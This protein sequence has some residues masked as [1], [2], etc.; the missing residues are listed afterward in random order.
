MESEARRRVWRCKVCEKRIQ[1]EEEEEAMRMSDEE[2]EERTGA[3]NKEE[4]TKMRAK[5]LRILQWNADG[6]TG[7]KAELEVLQRRAVDV[8]VIQE[9]KL[10]KKSVTPTIK[11]YTAVRKDKVMLR[12]E[13][14]K[15][16]TC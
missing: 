4:W 6:L 3:G 9:T 2:R 14:M 11:G 1:E 7:K 12:G 15:G 8:A 13:D 5:Q 16:E 10:G